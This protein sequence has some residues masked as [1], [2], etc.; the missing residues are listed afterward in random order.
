[1]YVVGEGDGFVEVCV[2]ILE[3]QDLTTLNSTYAA[4]V[5]ITTLQNGT[6]IG[7]L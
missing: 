2:A 3:P 5:D 6:A 4:S 1:M 7:E